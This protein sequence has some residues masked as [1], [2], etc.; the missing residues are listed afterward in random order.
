[1][2]EQQ[3]AKLDKKEVERYYD[4][5]HGEQSEIVNLFHC[6]KNNTFL[7]TPHNE[8]K[9]NAFE[10]CDHLNLPMPKECN[11]FEKPKCELTEL[12]N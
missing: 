6:N 4:T 8:A 2:T 7:H 5:H 10:L 3:T 1:M 9:G 12:F 11:L